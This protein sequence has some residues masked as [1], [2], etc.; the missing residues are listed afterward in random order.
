MQRD[1]ITESF[2][3]ALAGDIEKLLLEDREAIGFAYEKINTG[4]KLSLGITLDP[5]ADGIAVSYRICL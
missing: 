3:Q 5:T 4:M 1:K 2:L